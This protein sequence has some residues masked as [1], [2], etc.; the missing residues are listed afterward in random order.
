M[1]NVIFMVLILLTPLFSF[2]NLNPEFPPTFQPGPFPLGTETVRNDAP[3][4]GV[5]PDG[6][7]HEYTAYKG[8]VVVDGNLEDAEWAKIPWT[9]MEFNRDIAAGVEGSLWD[10]AYD[11]PNWDAW[12]DLTT[13]FKVLHDDNNIYVALMRRDDNNSIV[14]STRDSNGNI[15]QNDAYQMIVDARFPGDFEE[16]MPGSEIGF[17][18]IEEEEVYTYWSTTYQNPSLQLELAAG[19]CGSTIASATDKAIHGSIVENADGYVETMEVA[20]VKWPEISY[21]A[22]GMFTI[23][24]LDR[25]YDIHESVNQW[26]QGLFVKTYEEYGSILWSSASAPETAVNHD[27]RQMPSQFTLAQNYPNPFNPMTTIS[28]ELAKAETISLKVYTLGGQEVATIIDNQTQPEGQYSVTFDASQLTS[29]VYIYQL[30]TPSLMLMQ[31]MTV[32][33]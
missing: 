18:L 24:A 11:A 31:K 15:W 3:V 29:G 23:C 25:D 21:D 30:Q 27:G 1:K 17:G 33:K 28:Y 7:L 6:V 32:L 19:D 4:D 22:L 5:D 13:W 26:A 8:T 20:F 14:A 10:D 9:L 16:E 12:E 2:D